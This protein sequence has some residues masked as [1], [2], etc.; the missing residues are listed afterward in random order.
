MRFYKD[1][2]R[3]MPFPPALANDPGRYYMYKGTYKQFGS[4]TIHSPDEQG[5]SILQRPSLMAY[6]ALSSPSDA[7]I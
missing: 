7:R 6:M 2:F 4:P 1:N 3:P 5:T